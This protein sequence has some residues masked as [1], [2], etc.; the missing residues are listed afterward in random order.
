MRGSV[1]EAEYAEEC[2]ADDDADADADADVVS[3]SDCC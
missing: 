2:R 1:K 3:A